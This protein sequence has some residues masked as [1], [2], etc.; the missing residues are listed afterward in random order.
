MFHFTAHAVP[1]DLLFRDWCEARQLWDRMLA[2]GPPR[3]LVVM[4]DHVHLM[5]RELEAEAWVHFLRSY[6]CWR[7]HHRG[8]V[9]RR[10]WLPADPPEALSSAKHVQRTQRY[11]AL[12]PCRDH[13]A[14][15]PLA[16]AFGHHR[17]AV[18]LAVPGVVPPERDPVGHH[19]Y[20][21]GDPSVRVEG[22]ELPGGLSGL[23]AATVAQ[24]RD[25][26]S[27]LS[28]TPVEDLRQRGPART[29]LI[30]SLVACTKLPARTIAREVGVSH[31]A[32]LATEPIAT[33]TLAR[34]ECVLGD[35]RFPAL[36]TRDLSLER[37]FR[38]YVEGRVRRGAYAAL[39]AKAGARLRGHR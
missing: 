39:E 31:P 11:I 25:A 14:G 7:G 16:W 22:T 37:T 29:L 2:L 34:V 13:L 21:S 36:S 32:V 17:D 1:P 24:V 26:V 6:A 27:A 9:G 18:G 19:A 33:G 8:D 38:R 28:R 15:D 20:V 3:A 23:R 30:Q 10:V 5:I 12:N 35:P 4:P